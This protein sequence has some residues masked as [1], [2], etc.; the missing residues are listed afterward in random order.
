VGSYDCVYISSIRSIN[1]AD[2]DGDTPL[3][4]ASAS[5]HDTVVGLLLAVPG[6]LVNAVNEDG[7]T[8]L[9]LAVAA[10]RRRVAKLLRRA[11]GTETA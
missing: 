3:H 4:S 7:L 10:G 5:G 8:P 9:D 6:V 2:E 1:L 11:G